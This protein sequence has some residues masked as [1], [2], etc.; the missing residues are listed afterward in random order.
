M[1]SVPSSKLSCTFRVQFEEANE[2]QLNRFTWHWKCL[3]K[4]YKKMVSHVL[5]MF[6]VI[7]A[8]SGAT[9]VYYS[10]GSSTNPQKRIHKPYHK[11]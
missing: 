1:C 11:E 10:G 6:L 2:L 7:M 4:G 9:P 8:V 3:D 5:I